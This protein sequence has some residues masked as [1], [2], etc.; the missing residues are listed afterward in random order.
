MEP[1]K[2]TLYLGSVILSFQSFRESD[3]TSEACISTVLL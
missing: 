1:L 2:D 3:I